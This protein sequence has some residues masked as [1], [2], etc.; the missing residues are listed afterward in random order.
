MTE[1]TSGSRGSTRQS[2][3]RH[4]RIVALT[5]AATLAVP[6]FGLLPSA[7]ALNSSHPVAGATVS[8]PGADFLRAPLWTLSQC[9]SEAKRRKTRC[10]SGTKIPGARCLMSWA[11]VLS[12]TS[13]GSLVACKKSYGTVYTWMWA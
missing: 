1:E 4:P 8:V 13:S 6:A 10:D 7:Q 9:Q 5:L 11:G 12:L 3:P 2:R